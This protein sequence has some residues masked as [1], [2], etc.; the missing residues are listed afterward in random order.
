MSVTTHERFA[1]YACKVGTN[2]INHVRSIGPK[3]GVQKMEIIPSGAI[4]RLAIAEAF[5]DGVAQV[6]TGDLIELLAWLSPLNGYALTASPATLLQFQ[7]R[8][9]GGT[10]MGSGSHA[11]ITS[12]K[13]FVCLDEISATQDAKEGASAKFSIYLL[14]DGTNPA[15]SMQVA[16]NLSGTI[17][18]NDLFKLGPVTYEG[19]SVLGVESVVFRTGIK[20]STKRSSG[21][22]DPDVASIVERR[23][24][25]E[26][27]GSN[28]SLVSGV[29]TNVSAMSSGLSATFTNT[30]GGMA[31]NVVVSLTGGV[32]TASGVNVSGTGDAQGSIVADGS[33]ANS[34]LSVTS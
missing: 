11:T 25:I 4:D 30:A 13:V 3:F 32:Y 29:G 27:K 20:V 14:T 5:R 12:P 24:M 16:Q 15:L 6:T 19:S 31:V 21:M 18:V 8:A 10:W 1:G 9:D 28:L 23:P 7:Q 26:V 17:A 22:I 2:V 33:G 34:S